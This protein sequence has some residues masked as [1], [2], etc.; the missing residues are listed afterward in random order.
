MEAVRT[1]DDANLAAAENLVVTGQ[2][3]LVDE[4]SAAD[5]DDGVDAL[6][7]AASEGGVQTVTEVGGEA[8]IGRRRRRPVVRK[9]ER[10]R[11]ERSKKSGEDCGGRSAL[12][13]HHRLK[14]RTGN[15]QMPASGG[16]SLRLSSAAGKRCEGRSEEQVG[17]ERV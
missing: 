14:H 10:R 8:G 16:Q 5:Q 13:V 7:V 15:P 17:I 11:P 9:C 4:L 2:I 6:V 1:E 3:A 12:R